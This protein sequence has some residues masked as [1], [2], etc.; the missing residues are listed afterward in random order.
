MC[1]CVRACVHACVCVC[2]LVRECELAI[3]CLYFSVYLDSISSWL[4]TSVDKRQYTHVYDTCRIYDKNNAN[5]H[6]G[7]G[8]G[9]D[10][11]Q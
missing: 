3:F 11:T 4:K 7:R 10:V 6:R 2:V 8:A 1:V 9:L 5:I